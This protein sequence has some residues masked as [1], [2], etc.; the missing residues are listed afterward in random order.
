MEM[1]QALTA[2]S[3][4]GHATRLSIFRL[5]VEAGPQG[6]MAGD[7]GEALSVPAATLSFHLKDL[8]AAGLIEGETQ[9]RYI[10]YRARFDAMNGLIE[11]LT[12]NCCAGSTSADCTPATGACLPTPAALSIP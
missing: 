1:K 12:H 6:R 8:A 3:A 4:L 2:L 9:G 10:C 7:L 5:L 11:F